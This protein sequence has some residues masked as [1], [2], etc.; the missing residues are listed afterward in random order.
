MKIANLPQLPKDF[1]VMDYVSTQQDDYRNPFPG[2]TKP[3]RKSIPSSFCTRLRR[4]FIGYMFFLK[5]Q[6]MSIPNNI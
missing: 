3:V 6:S 1:G 4:E 5:N 2:V